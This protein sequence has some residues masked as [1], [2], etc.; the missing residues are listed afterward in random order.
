VRSWSAAALEAGR[1]GGAKAVKTA[2]LSAMEG[3][4]AGAVQTGV[5]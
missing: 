4:R 2:A 1:R 3:R 5:S